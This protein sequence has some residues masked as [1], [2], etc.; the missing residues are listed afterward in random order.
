MPMTD[1]ERGFLEYLISHGNNACDNLI[2]KIEDIIDETNAAHKRDLIF[3]ANYYR[4]CLDTYTDMIAAFR[5]T[6]DND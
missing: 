4:G 1:K 6:F 5:H 3:D 2:G